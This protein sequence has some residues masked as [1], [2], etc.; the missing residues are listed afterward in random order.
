MKNP[1]QIDALLLMLEE[2]RGHDGKMLDLAYLMP[3]YLKTLRE[4]VKNI[5]QEYEQM[6]VENDLLHLALDKQGLLD[7]KDQR[8]ETRDQRPETRDQRPETLFRV[9]GE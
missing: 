4:S 1:S 7:F 6:S 2:S 3:K 8:P 9:V 5:M